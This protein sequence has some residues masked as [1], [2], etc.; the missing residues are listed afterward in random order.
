ML[1]HVFNYSTIRDGMSLG[2]GVTG[3]EPHTV[4][5]IERLMD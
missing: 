3:L 1:D 4:S 2:A 5:E